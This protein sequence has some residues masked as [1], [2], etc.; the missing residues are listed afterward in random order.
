M[1]EDTH[2]PCCRSLP[3]VF[4]AMLTATEE[5]HAVRPFALYSMLETPSQPFTMPITRRSHCRHHA[6]TTPAWECVVGSGGG[7]KR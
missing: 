7:G 5:G 1:K 4:N 6:Q 3:Q 2:T